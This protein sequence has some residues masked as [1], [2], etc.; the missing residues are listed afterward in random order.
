MKLSLRSAESVDRQYNTGGQSASDADTI[1]AEDGR[2]RKTPAEIIGPMEAKARA[3]DLGILAAG[4]AALR[5][6]WS[7]GR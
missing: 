4:L 5:K 6:R 1:L 3:M 2:T 7:A